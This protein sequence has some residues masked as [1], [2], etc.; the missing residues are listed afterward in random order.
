MSPRCSRRSILRS[1]ISQER[2]SLGTHRRSSIRECGYLKSS[3]SVADHRCAHRPKQFPE[4]LIS[5]PLKSGRAR[6]RRCIR[7]Y[8]N[9]NR[10][11]AR[12][13]LAAIRELAGRI[14]TRVRPVSIMSPA[15]RSTCAMVARAA[16]LTVSFDRN[17]CLRMSNVPTNTESETADTRPINCQR[18]RIGVLDHQACMQLQ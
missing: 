18:L 15:V 5:P 1:P 4:S 6:A 10:A 3:T 7:G 11:A 2:R 9:K 13:E 14:K 16:L 17:G 12:T 8:R